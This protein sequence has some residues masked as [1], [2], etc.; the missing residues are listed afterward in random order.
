MRISRGALLTTVSS[1]VALALLI[2]GFFLLTGSKNDAGSQ[3]GGHGQL[4][5]PFTGEPVR[6][7]RRVVIFKIDN[8]AQARPPTGLTKA[9][10]VY[11]LP[12]EGGLSRIFAV[13]SSHFPPVIGPV[14]SSREEDIQLLRQFGRPAF[15]F[16]GAQPRLLPVVEHARI[17]DLYAGLV[18]GYFRS[19]KRIAP[20]NLYARTSKLLAEAKGASKARDI[21]FRF[22]P[23]PAGGKPAK[24]YNVGYSAAA[25]SIRW[26]AD[27]HRWLIWM[28]GK[29]ATAADGKKLGA[30]TV[31]IQYAKIGTSRFLEFPNVRPPYAHTVGAGG[32]VV[33]RNGRAYHVHW[34]RP[35]ADGG[36]AFTL[37]GGERMPF[38]RG[39]VWVIY[40]FG[41]GSSR[42][43]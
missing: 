42:Q 38:A 32:A 35:A 18:G 30:R 33:L 4:R 20:Y 27:Q 22:G 14:R 26:S 21:G 36:T 7:L 40:G 41:P 1:L 37:P 13:F 17:V 34:S 3:H 16:S 24:I 43:Q 8:V 25:F 15:A 39:Q 10:I 9:D 6:A 19:S 23:A 29:A 2:G 28:D 12:V 11:V 5:S 31:V